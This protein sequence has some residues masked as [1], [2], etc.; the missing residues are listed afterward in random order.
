MA[1]QSWTRFVKEVAEPVLKNRP[2]VDR[3]KGRVS[4][5]EGVSKL[6]GL[7]QGGEAHGLRDRTTLSSAP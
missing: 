5:R 6:T 2:S 3:A 4:R 7:Q 1:R